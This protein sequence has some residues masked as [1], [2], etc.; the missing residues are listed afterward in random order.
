VSILTD[1][2]TLTDR[3]IIRPH[4][5]LSS[6]EAVLV[7]TGFAAVS[8]TVGI[9]FFF[10]GL[11]L[12]LP[13]SGLELLALAAAFRY[14]WLKSEIREVVSITGERVTV[15][16]GRKCAEEKHEFQRAWVRV[17]L[18]RPMHPWYP[19]RLTL[20]SHGREVEIGAFLCE[21]E[22][23]AFAQALCRAIAR[24]VRE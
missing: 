1:P 11:S 3:Y 5:S 12:V 21:E 18:E 8:L 14:C 7:Y 23:Q 16:R 9:G 22:R 13:F 24:E 19:K 15:E 10:M 4:R 2:D 17:Q 20:R 6:R